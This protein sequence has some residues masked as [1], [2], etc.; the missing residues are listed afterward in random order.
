MAAVT[1]RRRSRGASSPVRGDGVV[2][3][4]RARVTDRTRASDSSPCCTWPR[5]RRAAVDDEQ[6]QVLVGEHAVGAG[7]PP[8]R[9]RARGRRRRR[10]RRGAAGGRRRRDSAS[11]SMRA[12]AACG[13]RGEEMRAS[14]SSVAGGEGEVALSGEKRASMLRMWFVCMSSRSSIVCALRFRL[15]SVVARP[16]CG[17]NS[18]RSSQLWLSSQRHIAIAGTRGA[19]SSA[20]PT[21]ADV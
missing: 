18:N 16:I 9:R 14:S 12:A 15:W 13:G 5:R 4:W 8:A 11:R 10:G 17:G 19:S 21:H 20:K 7:V 6:Q 3:Q 1:S 2:D